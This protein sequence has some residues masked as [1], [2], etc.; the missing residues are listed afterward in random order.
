VE[1][2]EVKQFNVYLPLWL[3]KAVKHHAVDEGSS[4]SALVAQALQAYLPD[5]T[6]RPRRSN[7]RKE[8]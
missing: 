2:D 8:L 3:I 1:E 7:V 4:L 5:D 6:N